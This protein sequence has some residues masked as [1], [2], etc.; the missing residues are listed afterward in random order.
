LPSPES[1]AARADLQKETV[2]PARSLAVER[3]EWD[4]YGQTLPMATNITSKDVQIG[5]VRCLKLHPNSASAP[6]LLYAHGGGLTTGSI[7]THR[8]FA[9]TLAA[10]TGCTVILPEYRL[11]P[12]HPVTAPRDDILAVC[13]QLLSAKTQVI[14]SGDS[15]GAAL[16]L[17]TMI[18]LRDQGERLPAGLISISGAFDATLSGASHRD[19]DGIDPILSHV[20]LR[21]WQSQLGPDFPLKD[22]AISPL[23]EPLHG[24]PPAL[25]LVGEDEVWL[26]DTRR[27]HD[28]F[29]DAGTASSL[30]I[31]EGMWHLFPTQ[32][33]LPEAQEA[34]HAIAQFC[35][36]HD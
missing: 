24:L 5:G 14:L 19:K 28:R 36:T 35:Q 3:A 4:A 15:S 21:H 11:L 12:E 18:M 27:L 9:S 10:A 1:I 17:A 16:A 22:P 13:R 20:V 6:A 30:R 29:L 34:L 26:D 23:F 25:L 8:A 7:L 32:S 2:N 31:F 33:D